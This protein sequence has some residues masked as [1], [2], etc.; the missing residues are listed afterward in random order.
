VT[1]LEPVP[2]EPLPAL[3]AQPA[4]VPWP[5]KDWPTGSLPGHVDPAELETLI[6][7][8][9]GP[10]PDPGFGESHALVIVHEGRIVAERYGAN[11]GPDTPLLSWSMAKS[12]THSLVG[13]LVKD[14]RLDPGAVAPI[15][16][17]RDAHDPRS[18]ITLQH[19]LRMTDGLEFNEDYS[20]PSGDADSGEAR[21][22]HCID[23]LFGSGQ[24][25]VAGYAIERPARHEPGVVFNYSS[26]T[27]NIVSRIIGDELGGGSE[28]LRS[29]VNDR[30]F[31]PIGVRTADLTFDAA[32]N[33]VGSSYLHM[34]ARD[35]ARFGL[36]NL[37]GGEWDGEQI[38]PRSWVEDCRR[39][40]AVDED[41][42][43]YGTHWWVGDDGR[44]SFWC[45]GFEIQRVI[46]VPRTD[47]VVV[48]L[49][50]TPQEN[51]DTPKVWLETI[52]ALFD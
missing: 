6:E 50:R 4:G 20:L 19:L 12:V 32:G 28:T 39:A 40:W 8:A 15:D 37:R 36:L 22:S 52:I 18:R 33:F 17:W 14:G 26:G 5:T 3:P 42:S 21:W 24:D 27:S 1:I 23:M 29:F 35:W 38:V 49:G 51:Y 31:Q 10:E 44:G 41:G 45:S 46:C 48:R 7:S 47:L 11:T 2:L 34:T 16:A 25:D 43:H 9:F 13:I 30:L